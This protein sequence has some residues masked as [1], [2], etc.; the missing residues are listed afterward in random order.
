MDTNHDLII[1][2]AGCA[3]LSL[4]TQLALMDKLAPKTL[5]LEQRKVYKNDRT[6]CF[7]GDSNNPFSDLASVRWNTVVVQS[8]DHSCRLNCTSAPYQLL[9]AESFY[10]HAIDLICH[11]PLVTLQTD[12]AI[13]KEPEFHDGTWVIETSSGLVRSRC[14]VDTRPKKPLKQINARLWQSFVGYEIECQH[15]SF[16]PNTAVLMDFCP[17]NSASVAFK[18]ILPQTTTRGLIEFT[19]FA[20][21]PFDESELRANLESAIAEYLNNGAFSIVRKES[22]LIPM[23]FDTDYAIPNG[24]HLYPTYVYAGLT[25]GAARAST[26][27]AFQRIQRWAI[28]CADSMAKTGLPTGHV[29]DQL[30]QRTMDSIF[31]KVLRSKPELGPMLFM[32]LFRKVKSKRLIRFLSDRGQLLDYLAVIKALPAAP[33]LKNIL[34]SSVE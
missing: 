12:V 3:G 21:D 29:A 20:K 17:A 8:G 26:G 34:A 15:A 13:T 5:L 33:F 22:G 18:Y 4:G 7:W 24:S 11:N 14:V 19:T 27:Y 31:L 2:G 28:Q 9:S 23:G 32:N 6:W 30:I 25:A 10:A 1:I 16:D